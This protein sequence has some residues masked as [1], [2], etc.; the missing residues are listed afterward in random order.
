MSRPPADDDDL[1]DD[2]YHFPDVTGM[3]VA[4]DLVLAVPRAACDFYRRRGAKRVL[5]MSP[6]VDTVEAFTPEDEVAFR[7]IWQSTK[8]FVLVLGRKSGAKGYRSVITAV[9]RLA[10]RHELEVAL[11]GPDDDGMPVISPVARYLG[12]Q[13]RKILR[14]A[15]RSCVALVNMSSSESFGMVLLEA[16]V[17]GKPVV[18]NRHCAAFADLAEHGVN[19]L[20]VDESTLTDAI[21]ALVLRPDLAAQLGAHGRVTAQQYDQPVIDGRFVDACLSLCNPTGPPRMREAVRQAM[22]QG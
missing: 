14:G 8:P 18:V 16:W 10:T 2:Y 4:A 17:A 12:P 19:A 5:Y 11:I 1:D 21:E 3:A 22:E 20:M 13:P 9:E 6:G 7:S 15:L